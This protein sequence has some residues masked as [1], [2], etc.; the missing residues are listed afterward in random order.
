[1]AYSGFR[2]KHFVVASPTFSALFSRE[3]HAV[4]FF[5]GGDKRNATANLLP[6]LAISHIIARLKNAET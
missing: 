3:R 5:I 2:L 6:K 4:C 1:M